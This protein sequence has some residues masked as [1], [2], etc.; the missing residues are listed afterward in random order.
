MIQ[1]FSVTVRGESHV[2]RETPCEDASAHYDGP[3]MHI[4][5]VSDG[6]GDPSCFRSS[7]GARLAAE[8]A[9]EQMKCFAEGLQ[10]ER[11]AY[12]LDAPRSRKLIIDRLIASIITTWRDQVAQHLALNPITEE[13]WASAGSFEAQYRR[14]EE[15]AH[16]YGA[17]LIAMLMTQDFFLALHQGD[18]RCI[19]IR[20]NGRID[21]PVPW[22][23]QCVGNVCT[24]LCSDDAAQGCRSLYIDLRREPLSAAFAC[25]DGVEDSLS[26]LE[27]TNAFIGALAGDFVQ[28]GAEGF[29]DNLREV[30]P[31]MSRQGSQDDISIAGFAC[32]ETLKPLQPMLLLRSDLMKYQAERDRA[33]ARISS[34]QRKKAYLEN[35]CLTAWGEAAD[36]CRTELDAFMAE[37]QEVEQRL[38]HYAAKVQETQ[39][40][41][42]R[43]GVPVRMRRSHRRPRLQQKHE[44]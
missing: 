31:E 44:E 20:P 7:E 40:V 1:S 29:M 26:S 42:T 25:T 18:G 22:D 8:V 2:R 10:Q 21:Q 32:A 17:T 27:H 33:Q 5:V 19:C 6:H 12:Q 3:G 9:M 4:A 24:S 13:E 35:R 11:E 30:L 39:A 28:L 37:Y 14:G 36:N 41:L 15:L 16:I 38:A 23:E 34:M 43:H